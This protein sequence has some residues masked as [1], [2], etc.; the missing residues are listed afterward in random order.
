MTIRNRLILM[1]AVPLVA[2]VI[3]A[4]FG[5]AQ[6]SSQSELHEDAQA[7]S[8]EVFLVDR[9]GRAIGT[10]RLAGA[11]SLGAETVNE[12]INA[13]DAAIETALA[14]G[15]P[16]VVQVAE[17]VQS[18]LGTGIRGNLDEYRSALDL[19]CLLYTSPSPRDS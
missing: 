10:E 12:S 7:S 19:V 2:L 4:G 1:L 18:E 3:V 16:D 5:F 11:G 9:I 15:S 17:N 6:L 14:E 8:A 13:T